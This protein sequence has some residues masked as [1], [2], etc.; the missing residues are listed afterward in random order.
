MVSCFQLRALLVQH[1]RILPS[2]LLLAVA[3]SDSWPSSF[4]PSCCSASTFTWRFLPEGQHIKYWV[5]LFPS[6]F[7]YFFSLLKK[8]RKF[9]PAALH[10]VLLSFGSCTKYSQEGTFNSCQVFR[11]V[12]QIQGMAVVSFLLS[13]KISFGVTSREKQWL[14]VTG[15]LGI[16][17]LLL[18]SLLRPGSYLCLW[19]YASLA[20]PVL[21]QCL[22]GMQLLLL[23][24]VTQPPPDKE[25]NKTLT[26]SC[27]GE[28]SILQLLIKSKH[29][30]FQQQ[31]V[32]LSDLGQRDLC[33][34]FLHSLC[35]FFHMLSLSGMV[36]FESSDIIII[37]IVIIIIQR[38]ERRTFLSLQGQLVLGT[39][40]R[41]I[42]SLFVGL[43][44]GKSS[45]EPGGQSGSS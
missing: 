26:G 9:L 27:I 18:P 35:S 5:A 10:Q 36:C 23:H 1:K 19:S 12:P 8:P 39:E 6:M 45:P 3:V 7:C 34:A 17:G 16:H 32:G 4:P 13:L 2:T 25:S 22:G 15:L 24:A 42:L 14:L 40:L 33:T 44:E 30:Y 31:E 29:P 11:P 28:N 21:K 37:T 38:F 41:N 20:S 43:L